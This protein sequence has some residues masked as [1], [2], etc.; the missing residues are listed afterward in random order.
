[1]KARCGVAFGD[2][3]SVPRVDTQ[4]GIQGACLSNNACS[5]CITA[6]SPLACIWKRSV[7]ARSGVPRARVCVQE[8]VALIYAPLRR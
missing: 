6:V 2:V 4:T 8:W 3:Q 7:P 1:M 5:V